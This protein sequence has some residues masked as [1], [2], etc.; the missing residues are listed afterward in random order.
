MKQ[1]MEVGNENVH[2][3]MHNKAW[4]ATL[5]PG[6][7][8]FAFVIEEFEEE[9]M[10]SLPKIPKQ[11]RYNPDGTTT[12][13]FQKILDKV[14]DNGKVILFENSDLTQ[15]C[16]DRKKGKSKAL[17]VNIFHNLT[18]LLDQYHE[19]WSQCDAFVIEM[20]MA[21][22]GVYNIAALKI[23]QHC[24]S[25]FTMKYGRGTYI[26][27]LPAY[28]K[29]QIL[30]APKTV[31]ITRGGKVSCKAMSKPERK[32]WC[33]KK[34]CEILTRREDFDTMSELNSKSKQDDIADCLCMCCV[35]RVLRY[36]DKS[37]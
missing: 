2:E 8:N 12:D 31:H 1:K 36:I 17:D 26:T 37:I 4:V 23:A 35:W 14:C 7:K 9:E 29:T 13:R 20:Q 22:R 25:Y 27:E 28:Y 16:V 6:Y 32:K 5:D 19:Y 21:F 30:G 15:G 18:E 33:T 24:F 3:N 11:L 10:R 34:A